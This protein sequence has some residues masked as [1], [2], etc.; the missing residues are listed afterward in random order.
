MADN[1]V[2]SRAIYVKPEKIRPPRRVSSREAITD[3]LAA[4]KITQDSET[5]RFHR[6]LGPGIPSAPPDEPEE[7]RARSPTRYPE[8]KVQSP[9][10]DTFS[11]APIPS[12]RMKRNDPG[13]VGFLAFVVIGWALL[14]Y[15]RVNA[16]LVSTSW[17]FQGHVES[18]KPV[19]K[20]G[21]TLPAGATLISEETQFYQRNTVLDYVNRVCLPEQK[22]RTE[23]S[24]TDISC[25]KKFSHYEE[26]MESYSHTEETC[27]ASGRCEE[28]DV[29]VKIPGEAVYVD[30]CTETPQY[31]EVTYW[32]EVCKDIPVTHQEPEY[33]PY[34]RFEIMEWTYH[35]TVSTSS[36]EMKHPSE[37]LQP[38]ERY[39]SEVWTYELHFTDPN[40][41]KKVNER[42]YNEYKDKI[43]Q[44]LVVP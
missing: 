6:T 37:L 13:W 7:K 8:V 26:D 16:T 11:D 15:F 25:S 10:I 2:V 23:Y 34:Y 9:N 27:Y 43:G 39:K 35:G 5:V 38:G 44:I 40:I 22:T 19:V 4:E 18:M 1:T 28:E 42:T 3:R 14:V 41:T 30:H 21:W 17:S 29:Y 24:H 32:E 31:L 36:S 20:S 33:R 12:T